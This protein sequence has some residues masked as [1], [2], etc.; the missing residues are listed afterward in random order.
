MVNTKTTP[1]PLHLPLKRA[2][3]YATQKK[4][5]PRTVAKEKNKNNPTMPRIATSTRLV[6]VVGGRMGGMMM[7]VLC[8]WMGVWCGHGCCYI[9]TKVCEECQK[10]LG[11]CVFAECFLCVCEQ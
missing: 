10:Y 3:Q 11:V 2:I 5:K 1:P 6:M 4:N 9:C 7:C 8:M